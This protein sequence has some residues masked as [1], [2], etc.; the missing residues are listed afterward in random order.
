MLKTEWNK[1]NPDYTQCNNI[2]LQIKASN[3][4]SNNKLIFSKENRL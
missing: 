4:I 3:N 1:K 2:L